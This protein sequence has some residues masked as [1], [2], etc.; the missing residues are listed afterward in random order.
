MSYYYLVASLPLLRLEEEP[1]L[2]IE[3]FL[4]SCQG[5]LT[6]ADAAAA[7]MACQGRAGES[8]HPFLRQYAARDIQLRNAIASQRAA[9]RRVDA[10]PYLHEDAGFDVSTA[11][12]AAHA[13][14]TDNPLE[15][16][17]YL[18]TFRWGVVE[19]L[20][21]PA[22]FDARAVLGFALQLR[23]AWRW[24]AMSDEKGRQALDA[25]L[26]AQRQE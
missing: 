25:C 7:E 2:S 6:Q 16:E 12:A 23:L 1:P 18:D 9:R 22:S 24:A 8:D 4:A 13:L 11:Q 17:R 26:A 3:A 19:E 10:E 14:G 20:V 5:V 15:R 21:G